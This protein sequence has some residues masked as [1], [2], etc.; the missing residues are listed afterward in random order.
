[1]P[2][3]AA[4][5]DIVMS[6]DV[7]QFLTED[8]C[9]YASV[10]RDFVGIAKPNLSD[11]A[12]VQRYNEAVL[13]LYK[14]FDASTEFAQSVAFDPLDDGR[15]MPSFDQLTEVYPDTK[16]PYLDQPSVSH[17]HFAPHQRY[18][19]ENGYLLIRGLIDRETCDEYL[20]LREQLAL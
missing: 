5:L 4:D 15:A 14:P 19:A 16:C 1:M 9:D 17:A 7:D 13:S 8:V 3:S 18:W 10:A 20:A 6:H 12:A 2:R 11:A